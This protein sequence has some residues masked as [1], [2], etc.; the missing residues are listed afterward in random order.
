MRHLFFLLGLFFIPLFIHAGQI[1]SFGDGETVQLGTSLNR[2]K[3]IYPQALRGKDWQNGDTILQTYLLKPPFSIDAD[4]VLFFFKSNQLI[5]INMRYFQKR[6]ADRGGWQ[7]DYDALSQLFNEAGQSVTDRESYAPKVK[8]AFV[9]RSDPTGEGASLD[10]YPDDSCLVSF[11]ILPGRTIT[12]PA[13]S[14]AA[15]ARPV[16][17]I[18]SGEASTGESRLLFSPT[19]EGAAIDRALKANRPPNGTIFLQTST[20]GQ[21]ELKIDNGSKFDAL[22]KLVSPQRKY[23]F[24]SVYVHSGR[25]AV[26]SNIRPNTYKLI[27]AFGEGW[28][29]SRNAMVRIASTAA[30]E[31]LLTFIRSREQYSNIKITLHPVVGGNTQCVD[32]SKE[33]FL[34][35]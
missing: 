24:V 1:V 10:V 25:S 14:E 30:F 5:Q 9:W 29:D 21:G 11:N 15:K 19:E 2:F 34:A 27:Y 17:G 13:S 23:T 8:Y 3:R 22:V 20:Q 31:K 16:T 7:I 28:D 18:L 26:V 33:D 35:Y 4:E 12:D 32:I 6:S